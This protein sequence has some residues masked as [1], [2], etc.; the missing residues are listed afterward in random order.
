MK[1]GFDRLMTMIAAT[2]L[3]GLASVGFSSGASAD[4]MFYDEDM[5]VTINQI[6][7]S[8]T[9]MYVCEG[10]NTDANA[11]PCKGREGN[12]EQIPVDDLMANITYTVL[13]IDEDDETLT[14]QIVIENLTLTDS[15]IT[16]FGIITL[17]PK[18]ESVFLDQDGPSGW[19]T[20]LGIN[21]SGFQEIDFCAS[22][23]DQGGSGTATCTGG[24][25]NGVD[26]GNQE[27]IVVI[28]TF[29]DII[30]LGAGEDAVY[31]FDGSD[32]FSLSNPTIKFQ[33]ATDDGSFEFLGMFK[34]PPVVV[35]EPGTMG[36][37]GVALLGFGAAGRRKRKKAA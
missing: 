7:D 14:M 22:V 6:G 32:S 13:G 33:G 8:F 30:M 25:N 35:P 36:L 9:A 29:D 10:S 24:A 31:T 34:H 18:P 20:D 3:A 23:E 12:D 37:L 21:A 2:G 5:T 28:F 17:L 4:V 19:F 1:F 15:S 27:T 11:E 26:S 16:N